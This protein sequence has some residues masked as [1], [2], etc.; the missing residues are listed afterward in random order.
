MVPR[1]KFQS[2][3]SPAE[4]KNTT[5]LTY[6]RLVQNS[7]VFVAGS[8]GIWK[9]QDRKPSKRYGRLYKSEKSSLGEMMT[10]N[11]QQVF[12]WLAERA[13]EALDETEDEVD[14]DLPM[15]G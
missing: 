7:L 10:E 4:K 13:D 5:K 6:V 3:F 1:C 8:H 9:D 12:D 14:E 15:K 2:L 11:Q